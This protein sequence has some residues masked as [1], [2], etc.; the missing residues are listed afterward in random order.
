[1]KE[2]IYTIPINEAIEK[3]G[4]PLCIIENDLDE[5]AVDYY[6][7]DSVMEPAV[8]IE[9]N[10]KGF[11]RSH[12]EKMMTGRNRLSLALSLETR[13]KHIIEK[14]EKSAP[15]K[16]VC[17]HSCAACD[18]VAKQIAKCEENFAWLLKTEPGFRNK[19][20]VS[21]GLCLH[22]MDQVI[23]NLGRSDK[24]LAEKIKKHALEKLKALSTEI[25]YFTKKFDYRNQNLNW[26]GT[27]DSPERTIKKITR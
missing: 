3:C 25:T 22:H 14:I 24:A 10:E 15:L 27:E 20:F 19:Y 5:A 23:S 18:R 26:N 13:L 11:C 12:S 16:P 8:R 1:M 4:C 17:T 7:G 9:T 21:D 6:M 2:R